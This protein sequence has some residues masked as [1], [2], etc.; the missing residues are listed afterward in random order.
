MRGHPPPNWLSSIGAFCNVDPELFR[1]FTRYQAYPENDCY[2]GHPPL[3]MSRIFRFTFFTIV[4]MNPDGVPEQVIHTRR[5]AAA[6]KVR[7]YQAGRSRDIPSL[8]PGDSIVRNFYVL[9]S[10][11][12]VIEQEMAILTFEIGKTWM[13]EYTVTIAYPRIAGW[14]S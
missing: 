1:W 6:H 9:D 8:K 11:H 12:C 3:A 4:E 13:G 7:R 14:I 10:P 5:I 2:F